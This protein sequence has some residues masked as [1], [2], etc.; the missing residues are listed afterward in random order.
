[1]QVIE[2]MDSVVQY[3][4]ALSLFTMYDL[5]YL[6]FFILY[7]LT[8]DYTEQ[9]QPRDYKMELNA[10]LF[11]WVPTITPPPLHHHFISIFILILALS[12]QT[13]IY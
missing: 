12:L 11:S 5:H 2:Y 7:D 6:L 10:L 13:F 3:D 1:M 8:L 4:S 9:G